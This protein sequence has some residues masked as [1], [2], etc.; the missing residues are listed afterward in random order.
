MHEN[1]KNDEDLNINSATATEQPDMI[2]PHV[3]KGQDMPG[4]FVQYDVQDVDE[5]VALA[6]YFKAIGKYK[7]FR[8]Q[9]DASWKI[10]STFARLDEAGRQK[11]IADF[12]AFCEWVNESPELVPYLNSDNSLIATAQHHGIAATTFI[13]FSTEP[14]IA[15]WFATEGASIYDKGAIFMINP[16]DVYDIF[17]SLSKT[18]IR[19]GFIEI[20]VANLWRLQAQHG[21]FLEAQT[22]IE[23]IWPFDRIVFQQTN[24]PPKIERRRI[25][26]DRRSHLEQM[27][28]Q[29]VLLKKR[30]LAFQELMKRNN[31]RGKILHMEI[32][33]E[34][35]IDSRG[36]KKENLPGNWSSGPNEV[37]SAM[38]IEST[39]PTLSIS[40][41]NNDINLIKNTINLRRNCTDLVIINPNTRHRNGTVQ[42]I[43]NALWAG[44]RPH[45]YNAEEI[46]RS[47]FELLRF[48]R[49]FGDFP[50]DHGL[51]PGKVAPQ[52]LNDPIEIEMGIVGGGSTRAYIDGPRLWSILSLDARIHLGLGEPTTGSAVLGAL[53]P[54]NGNTLHFFDPSAL[55]NLFVE[56]IVP[57]QVV[58]RR[59]PI[60]FSPMHINTFGRP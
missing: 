26:P 54:Y 13:D 2:E 55:L 6:E 40:Q 60:A 19:I 12:S 47:T 3:W 28:D 5:A 27:I 18:G 11:A 21:L 32:S 46:S 53:D 29:H 30:Q 51:D 44:M 42:D 43:I 10:Q 38:D 4:G 22:D 7:F 35:D 8:G 23:R 58:T 33:N 1:V 17:E 9:R 37:W 57:W 31:G 25:Y 45:P 15:G 56:V 52:L 59:N 49:I 16:D 20:E 50:L 39:P 24:I 34:S 48:E 36:L 14:S 41:I